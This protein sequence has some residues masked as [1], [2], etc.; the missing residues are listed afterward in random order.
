MS[1]ILIKQ[2]RLYKGIFW[3]TDIDNVYSS[4][5][6]FLIPCD[7]NGNINDSDFEI[8]STMSAEHSDNYNHK[9]VWNTLPKKTTHGKSFDYY[10]RG[11]TEIK[12]GI[13]VIYH[14]PYIPQDDLKNWLI[15]KFNLTSS[16][17]IKKIRLVADGSNHYKCWLDY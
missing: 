16:N 10:P 7:I 2:N 12:N 11:R 1:E 5:L 3:I 6:Y 13:A 15:E 14:S 17:G 8:L 4:D 9:K